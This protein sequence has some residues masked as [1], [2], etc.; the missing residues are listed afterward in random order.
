VKAKLLLDSHVPFGLAH[1]VRALNPAA[2]VQHISEWEGGA[3]VSA[4]DDLVLEACWEDGRALLSKDRASLPGW[5]GLRVA[6]GKDHAGVLFY[7]QGRYKTRP[8]GALAKA[9]AAAIKHTKGDLRNR[10][11]TLH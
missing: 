2:D 8:I 6:D 4:A 3:Y 1:A 11:I 9:V 5:I 10:W 7:D